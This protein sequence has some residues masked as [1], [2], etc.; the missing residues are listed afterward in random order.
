MIAQVAPG[1]PVLDQLGPI[2]LVLVIGAVVVVTLLVM[3]QIRI[4]E[5]IHRKGEGKAEN[6]DALADE[7]RALRS[8]IGDLRDRVNAQAITLDRGVPILPDS[9]EI[10][11][12]TSS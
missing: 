7:I 9:Q 12:R 3:Y 4:A 5:L 6:R 11:G 8:E 2:I 10:H 1:P